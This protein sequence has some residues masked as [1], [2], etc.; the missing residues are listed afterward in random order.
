MIIKAPLVTTTN[1]ISTDS[2]Y[3]WTYVNTEIVVLNNCLFP[4]LTYLYMLH[5]ASGSLVSVLPISTR[6]ED[7]SCMSISTR[8]DISY[9]SISTREDISYMPISTREGYH[10]CQVFSSNFALQIY[11]V[12]IFFIICISLHSHISS[13]LCMFNAIFNHISGILWS[14]VVLVDV[15]ELHGEKPLVCEPVCT[16]VT[17]LIPNIC[18]I[19]LS[20]NICT[21]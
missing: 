10:T 1:V 5:Q 16:C 15:T 4:I 20:P 17:S 9:M 7:I 3:P 12:H 6:E 14:K 2:Y 18:V 19:N 8:E 13:V 11:P 21:N